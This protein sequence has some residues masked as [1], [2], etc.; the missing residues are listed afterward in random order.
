MSPIPASEYQYSW[1]TGSLG[2]NY[3]MG[4]GKQF[5]FGYAP[6]SGIHEQK[7]SNSTG[8]ITFSSNPSDGDRGEI[9]DGTNLVYFIFRS[10][11]TAPECPD[12]NDLLSGCNLVQVQLGGNANLTATSLNA[13]INSSI[14]K[15]SSTVSTNTLD[16]LADFIDEKF[17]NEI[18]TNTSNVVVVGMSGANV[19]HIPAM[20][21]PTASEIFG[22]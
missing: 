7:I 2:S 6:M 15:I 22:V 1:I 17:N 9:S 20:T 4:S 14:L 11:L 19:D 21:F 16:L 3:A 10:S 5:I 8:T 12:E 18:I 13:V